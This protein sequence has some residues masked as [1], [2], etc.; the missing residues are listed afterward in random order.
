MARLVA[1]VAETHETHSYIYN[2]K[3]HTELSDLSVSSSLSI[4]G[5]VWLDSLTVAVC[6][7][8]VGGG[9]GEVREGDKQLNLNQEEQTWT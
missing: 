9:K 7:W 3:N 5:S 8:G 6:K 2:L 4:V 1:H